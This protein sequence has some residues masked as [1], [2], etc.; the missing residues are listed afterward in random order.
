MLF[1]LAAPSGEQIQLNHSTSQGS[2]SEPPM[3]ARTYV[4]AVHVLF[5]TCSA[6]S[7]HASML[8]ACR[9][10][11]LMALSLVAVTV[12]HQVLGETVD[13]AALT[14]ILMAVLLDDAGEDGGDPKAAAQAAVG[15][16]L[17]DRG[18]VEAAAHFI[19]KRFGKSTTRV[20]EEAL[21]EVRFGLLGGSWVLWWQYAVE[22]KITLEKH[23]ILKISTKS[24]G[25][26]SSSFQGCCAY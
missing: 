20:A 9:A 22:S 16:K 8:L 18:E 19:I 15:G 12:C 7:L 10:E 24:I 26:T 21:K 25:R 13:E 14:Q 4:P 5:S 17:A 6:C 2:L 11:Q 1:V 3:S 23:G